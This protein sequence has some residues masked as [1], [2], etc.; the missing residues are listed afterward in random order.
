MRLENRRSCC[1]AIAAGAVIALLAS[2]CTRT[3]DASSTGAPAKSTT[4]ALDTSRGPGADLSQ[5]ITG[6]N[7]PFMGEAVTPNLKKSGYVEHEY[8]ASGTATA[9]KA[10]GPLSPDGRWAFEPDTNAAYR[11]RILVRRP[12]KAARFSGTVVLEWLNV[13]GGVDA[14]PDY[15]SL[16]EEV[17]RRG[18]VWV[19]VSAQIIGVEGGPVLVKAP[20]AEDLA[21]KGLKGLD[22]P[23]YGS[24]Q[25]PGDGY[26][27]DI[28]TQVAQAV[29]EGGPAIGNVEPRWILAAGESQSAIALTTYYNGVQPLTRA[30]DGFLVHSRASVSLPLVEPGAYADLAGS[31]V[32]ST[33]V[34]FRTDLDAPVLDLQT[35]GD[36]T[37]ILNSV[38]V[39][40]PDSKRFRLWEVAGTAHA[41]VHLLGP[42]ADR[43]DCGAPINNGPM[44]IVAK[45]AL[46][47]LDE[48]V[49]TG[50]VPPKAP[51]LEVTD[52]GKPQIRRDADGIALGGIR[53][54]PVDVPVDVLSGIPGPNPD[55][56][57]ILLGS[58]TP[59]PSERLAA[60]YRSRD[61]YRQRYD[62]AANKVIRAGFALEGERDALRAFADPSRIKR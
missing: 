47:T 30:F 3:A 8:V 53:T 10:N 26:A 16:K 11:T 32:N 41:D 52:E 17:T 21:G 39:R 51:R 60:L 54:P 61:V 57:C 9:Y 42:I 2:A 38:A 37:S 12:E 43:I 20:G 50:N 62:A 4:T 19:G 1:A 36:V 7:G 25:H 27:F 58:T 35:E 59:L 55:L 33:P 13:S 44:H 15:A 31:I 23:R 49:R 6:G 18:D 34:T 14:N 22:P 56:L 5:E 40:Q 45:A 24:L 29:R 48:W 46:R 28:F